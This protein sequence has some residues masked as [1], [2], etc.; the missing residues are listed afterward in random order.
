MLILS[1]LVNLVVLIPLCASLLREAPSM[2][3]VFGPATPARGILTAIY[4]TFAAASIVVLA[5]LGVPELSE[6]IAVP[7]LSAQV[8]YKLATWPL[9]GI[10]NVVVRFNLAIAIL[11]AATLVTLL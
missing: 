7:L 1:M 5:S 6:A 3:A 10:R 8:I 2:D 11:H 9:V 4:L